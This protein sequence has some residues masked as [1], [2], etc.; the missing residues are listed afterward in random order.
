MHQVY[1]TISLAG[2]LVLV[3][4][5]CSRTVKKTPLAEPL[6]AT[7]LGIAA[8]PHLLGWVDLAHWGKPEAI[9]VEATRL[10]L[11]IALMGV[12]LRISM[13]DLRTVGRPVLWLLT[14]GM[15]LMTGLGW[16]TAWWVLGLA[17]VLA[18]LVGAVLAPTDP[19]VSSS[20]VSGE[21]AASHLPVRVRAVLSL[22]SGAN[23]GLA[24]PFVMLPL[25]LLTHSPAGEPVLTWL[26]DRFLVD[27]V[28][29]ALG[30]AALGY[31]TGKALKGAER[32]GMVESYSMLTLTISLSLLTLGLARITGTD[33]LVAV[34]TAGL[35][36]NAA[37]GSADRQ[38]E[39]R[40]QEGV[41]QLSTLP[42][43]LLFGAA[44]PW[45]DW[46]EAPWMYALFAVLILVLRRPPMFLALW[47][48]LKRPPLD[49]RDMAFL[50]W[51]GPLGV[52]A[53][54]YSTHAAEKSGEG[55][56]WYA[57]AAAVLASVVAHGTSAASL[58]MLYARH[59]GRQ[60]REPER[61]AEAMS[62]K[63]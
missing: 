42:V 23:D 13:S 46:A 62:A 27:V 9:L 57:G 32:L 20:I 1:V 41:N 5:L 50:G 22:E 53:I 14:A 28:L 43:F 54:F 31:A 49:G 39:E 51:F 21:F 25:L 63:S 58:T 59:G 7:L 11:S 26:L 3:L 52:A 24:Y 12:A 6:I 16:L 38:A 2:V 47:P 33:G 35:A 37:S 44:L 8:G 48:I 60:P 34:F 17:P 45:S 15:L 30:G 10:A 18:L 4:A 36:F 40:V 29:A 61:A 19:V 56:V 55:I